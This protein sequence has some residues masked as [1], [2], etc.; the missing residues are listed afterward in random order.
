MHSTA[1]EAALGWQDQWNGVV[2]IGTRFQ[3]IS[4]LWRRSLAVQKGRLS[5]HST[6]SFAKGSWRNIYCAP[7]ARAIR[8]D[9]AGIIAE[10]QC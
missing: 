1:T 10:Q 7:I 6:S 8:G 9:A 3:S 2:T 4:Q 5:T